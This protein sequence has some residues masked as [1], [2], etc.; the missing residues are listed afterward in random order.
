MNKF[1]IYIL[2][3]LIYLGISKSYIPGHSRVVTVNHKNALT[4][5][6]KGA[7]FTVILI[8]SFQVGLLIKSYFQKYKIIYGFKRPE[9]ITVKTTK[10][11]WDENLINQGM[12]IYRRRDTKL[13]GDELTPSPPGMIFVG[14]PALWSLGL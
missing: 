3:I 7:P 14:D 9:I 2:L 8:E 11:F 13:M 4:S 12:S 10:N 1:S 5:L 6:F